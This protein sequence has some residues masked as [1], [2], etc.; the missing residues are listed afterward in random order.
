MSRAMSTASIDRRDSSP[1]SILP[2]RRRVPPVQP[3]CGVDQ[4]GPI[5][6]RVV[7]RMRIEGREENL[8]AIRDFFLRHLLPI[9]RR[10]GA[11]LWVVGKPIGDRVIAIR[12]ATAYEANGGIAEWRRLEDTPRRQVSLYRGYHRCI[13]SKRSAHDLDGAGRTHQGDP[14]GSG[15]QDGGHD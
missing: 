3:D 4:A 7:Y 5:V 9:Q 8:E 1:T 2:I 10:Y 15:M 12:E 6:C 11:V 13:E 14:D